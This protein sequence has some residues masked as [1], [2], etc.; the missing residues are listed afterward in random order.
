MDY[1]SR[2]LPPDFDQSQTVGLIAGR[3][4][5]PKLIA[6]RARAKGIRIRLIAFE[7]ATEELYKSFPEDERV[8][9]NVGQ[10]GKWLRTLRKFDCRYTIAA[11]Q[12]KPGK[13]FRGLKPDLKAVGLLVK[14]KRKS[15]GTIFGAVAD[16]LSK[17]HNHGVVWGN[18]FDNTINTKAHIE[19][20]ANEIWSQTSG[21]IDGFTCAVGTGGTL[22][23]VGKFLKEKNTKIKIVLSDPHGSALYNFYKNNE[24]HSEGNSITEGIGQGRITKNLE[25]IDL[26]DVIRIDDKEALNVI[27]KLLKE[28]S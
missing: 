27:F 14:L 3:G 8:R 11:G 6:D 19:T 21:Q 4:I 17:K 23:G 28:R 10:V 15:A 1:L 9:I 24:L 5:Y 12:V 2:Y 18:Q 25:N 26:D 16:E 22:S 13:L 7:E 20:T